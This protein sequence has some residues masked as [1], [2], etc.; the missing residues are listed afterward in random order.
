MTRN[1]LRCKALYSSFPDEICNGLI[2]RYQY[3]YTHD[4][5]MY[6]RDILTE[7]LKAG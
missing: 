4:N 5:Y 2:I 1:S 6:T 7:I 3:I